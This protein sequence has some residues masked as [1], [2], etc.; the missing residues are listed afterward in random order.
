MQIAPPTYCHCNNSFFDMNFIQVLNPSV[1][2]RMSFLKI[3]MRF[4][5]AF[6]TL[7]QSLHAHL[8]QKYHKTTIPSTGSC[9]SP[10]KFV[11]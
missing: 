11:T 1:E 7:Y 8:E 5:V 2:I 6:P 10:R 9:S 3:K 4:S